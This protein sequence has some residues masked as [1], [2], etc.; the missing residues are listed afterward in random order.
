MRKILVMAMSLLFITNASAEP[1]TFTCYDIYMMAAGSDSAREA[2]YNDTFNNP[3]T[4]VTV[5]GEPA[6]LNTG[7][8]VLSFL[9]GA[10]TGSIPVVLLATF[11]P[12]AVSLI[13]NAPNKEERALRML[14]EATRA[15]TRFVEKMQKKISPEVTQEEIENLIIEGFD[16]GLFCSSVP[17][18]Y[19]ATKI[20]KY[21][22]KKLEQRYQ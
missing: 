1:V 5:A 6:T 20:K 11:A 17:K 14:D 16:T 18:L 7:L 3:D 22:Q 13:V 8:T 15:Q 4:G 12:T 10:I 21:V 2:R 19:S 9:G